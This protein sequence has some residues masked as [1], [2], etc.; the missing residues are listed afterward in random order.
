LWANIHHWG[1]HVAEPISELSPYWPSSLFSDSYWE[2]NANPK[3]DRRRGT[4]TSVTRTALLDAAEQLICEEGYAAASARRLASKAGL[5]PQLV[6]Y[7]FRTMDDLFV[8]VVRRS[9]DRSLEEL[10]KALT[11]SQPLRAVWN[12]GNDQKTARLSVEFLALA[13]HRKAIRAEVKQYAEQMRIVQAAALTRQFEVHGAGLG[14]T[15]LTAVV[16]TVAT[17]NLLFLESKLGISLG[18]CETQA[19]IERS[20]RKI[21]RNVAPDQLSERMEAS[22]ASPSAAVGSRRRRPRKVAR[23]TA[24]KRLP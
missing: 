22:T 19:F 23:R 1:Q 5:K 11:S 20:L 7:Y 21:E 6:H 17:S 9:G 8:A 12:V 13:N 2:M 16:M 14:I 15:P 24:R 3:K 4:E 10:A 18:H